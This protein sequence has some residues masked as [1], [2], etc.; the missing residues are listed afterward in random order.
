MWIDLPLDVQ[1]AAIDEHALRSY[2]PD[3]ADLTPG[4]SREQIDEAASEAIRLL[5]QAERPVI[6]VGNGVRLGDARDSLR[7]LTDRLQVP[8]LASWLAHDLVPDDYPLMAGRPGPMA[9][10]GANFTLQNADYLLILG[11]RLGLVVTG[12][13]PRTLRAGAHAR[14]WSTSIQP[15]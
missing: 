15:S 3:A 1:G 14:S 5:N 10:R 7:A 9:P 2:Q 12:Y 8:V 11:A 13:A 4:L 6:L